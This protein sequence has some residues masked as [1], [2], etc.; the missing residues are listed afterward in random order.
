[1]YRSIKFGKLKKVITVEISDNFFIFYFSF[2]ISFFSDSG[3]HRSSNEIH[4]HGAS[5]SVNSRPSNPVSP[6]RRLDLVLGSSSEIQF[7]EKFNNSSSNINPITASG[8]SVGSSGG[9]QFSD[10]NPGVQKMAR[11][12]PT[13]NSFGIH[14]Q[15]S[16]TTCG[17]N[18]RLPVQD[19][20]GDQTINSEHEHD[21]NDEGDCGL[22]EVHL[23][24]PA[25]AP[26]PSPGGCSDDTPPPLPS[27]QQQIS[28]PQTSQNGGQISQSLPYFPY[29]Q[30]PGRSVKSMCKCT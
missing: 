24:R 17:Q 4:H 5:L 27:R 1:M 7:H 15:A 26:T 21:V 12:I 30:F 13:F 18:G 11:P 2:Q 29:H 9:I 19:T 28:P 14:H 3:S 10:H 25:Y 23:A 8:V 20:V 6:E 22:G 16:S